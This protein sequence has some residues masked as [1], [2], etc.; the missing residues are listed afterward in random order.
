MSTIRINL[1]EGQG[2]G[3]QL[4]NIASAYSL[5]KY[6]G[7]DLQITSFQKF[8]A[9]DF[10]RLPKGILTIDGAA[11]DPLPVFQELMYNDR[12]LGYLA[13]DFDA[14]ITEITNSAEIRGLFQSESY[15]QLSNISLSKLFRLDEKLLSIENDLKDK[16]ILNIRGGEYKR[17]QNLI[18][19]LDYWKNGVRELQKFS[20]VEDIVIVTDDVRYASLLFP[21]LRTISGNIGECYAALHYGRNIIVSN[22]SFSYFPIMTRTEVPDVIAPALWARHINKSNIWASP[23]NYYPSWNWMDNNGEL[24]S[25]VDA[26]N[27]VKYT[28][29][30]YRDNYKVLHIPADNT[31]KPKNTVFLK[32][33]VKSF[34][35]LIWPRKF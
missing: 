26:S 3:N 6:L 16:T 7:F 13:S 22:S 33:I 14:E 30:Y 11:D 32:K 5:S 23:C 1:Q 29:K 2:L 24:L 28:V 35:S 10:I 25:A 27:I 4:W 34:L 8:K 9:R 19:P 12:Q 31:K 15:L 17:H 20:E 21:G 18:L